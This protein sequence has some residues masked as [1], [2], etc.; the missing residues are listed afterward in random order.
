MLDSDRTSVS[1][2]QHREARVCVCLGVCLCAHDCTCVRRRRDFKEIEMHSTA[3]TWATMLVQWSCFFF[4]SS[5]FLAAT[6]AFSAASAA[7]RSYDSEELE[8]SPDWPSE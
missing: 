2:K 8:L 4:R 7:F 1:K 3:A 6:N 5:S